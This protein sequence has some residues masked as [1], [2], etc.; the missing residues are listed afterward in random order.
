MEK[1]EVEGWRGGEIEGW[2]GEGWIGGGVE[3]MA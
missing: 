2:K 3:N 1:E